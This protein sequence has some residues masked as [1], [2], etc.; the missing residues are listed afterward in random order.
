MDNFSEVV[1]LVKTAYYYDI[2]EWI[3][4]YKKLGFNHITIYDNESSVDLMSLCNNYGEYITYKKIIGTKKYNTTTER[5]AP[6]CI[7]K[8]KAFTNSLL[9]TPN[10]FCV[11][12]MCPVDDTGRNSV[13]PSTIAIIIVS[14]ILIIFPLCWVVILCFLCS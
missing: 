4:Y 5:I 2:V 12:I 10:I 14:N 6:N 1:L 11:I 7:I 3:N 8:V 13:N 9:S